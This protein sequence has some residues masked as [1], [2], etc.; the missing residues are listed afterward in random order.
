MK[1]INRKFTP[2]VGMALATKDGQRCGNAFI[3]KEEDKNYGGVETFHLFH[4]LTDFGNIMR[5]TEN[6]VIE[7]FDIAD[8]WCEEVTFTGFSTMP[9]PSCPVARIKRQMEL[10]TELLEKLNAN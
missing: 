7:L 4:V 6:E 2:E 5:L 3:I 8:W 9:N 10:L 1:P